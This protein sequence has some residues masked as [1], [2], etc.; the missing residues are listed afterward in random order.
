MEKVDQFQDK[1]ELVL[2][3][4]ENQN[5]A[6]QQQLATRITAGNPPIGRA[7]R[8]RRRRLVQRPMDDSKPQVAK[9]KP[10]LSGI[11]DALLKFYKESQ[12]G[13]GL[14][15]AVFPSFMYINKDIFDE[16]ELPYPQRNSARSTKAKPGTG[17]RCAPWP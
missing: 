1:I 14:P 17:T 15:Y 5:S 3:I 7:T 13:E 9:F 2:E 8:T 11:D 10:D 16:A 6:S 12:G 4:V